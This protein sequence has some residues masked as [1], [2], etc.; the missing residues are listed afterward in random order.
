M[1]AIALPQS[2]LI[3]H[4]FLYRWTSRLFVTEPFLP[5]HLDVLDRLQAGHIRDAAEAL[6][7]HLRVSQDRAI[8]RVNLIAQG[9][10][11]DPLRYLEPLI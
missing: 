10:Y 7:T 3:A 8:Y 5:E 1:Q 4:R 9:P 2:L 6:E 11:P